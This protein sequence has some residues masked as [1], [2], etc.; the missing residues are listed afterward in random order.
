MAEGECGV[1]TISSD[2]GPSTETLESLKKLNSHIDEA[3][4][5]FNQ[6][7]CSHPGCILET[8]MLHSN[9][10]ST[11]KCSV[12]IK[13]EN[14]QV[15]GSFK[16]R[17]ALY[18]AHSATTEEGSILVTASTGNHG[19]GIVHAL[20]ITGGKGLIFLPHGALA[21]KVRKLRDFIGDAD[22][23]LRFVGEDSAETEAA[24]ADYCSQG[25]GRTFVSPYNDVRV[26]AGQ[27][28]I[29]EEITNFLQNTGRG[30][31]RKCCY[32]TVGGGGLVCGV[33]AR[34]KAREPGVW[35]VVGCAPRNSAVLFESA[36][37][38]R[39]LQLES[40][41]TLS[42]GSAGGVEEGSSTLGLSRVLVDAWAIV[43]EEAI[44]RAMGRMFV[45]HR[46]VIEGAG[47]VAV[48]GFVADEE[49]RRVNGCETAVIV[50]CGA[51]VDSKVFVEIV[52]NEVRQVRKGME[53]EEK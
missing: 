27:G 50:A 2:E 4:N 3:C 44:G 46:K 45:E 26:M 38:G 47:G 43:D 9:W 17:G 19:M 41:P 40:M 8:P 51:N 30:R 5:V 13:L 52:K 48:G 1:F 25:D 53:V 28:T 16:A 6:Y 35:R 33:A 42:D 37:V 34:L 14:E 20:R 29:G 7:K 39:V 49:W 24:A 11:P 21:E 18:R 31:T 23:E 22:I 12:F 10:L 32:V 36:R 15:T